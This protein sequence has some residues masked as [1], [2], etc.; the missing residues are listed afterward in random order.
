MAAMTKL[1][2]RPRSFFMRFSFLFVE[3]TPLSGQ[4]WL[5]GQQNFQDLAPRFAIQ[6]GKRG[7]LIT[8]GQNFEQPVIHILFGLRG[9]GIERLVV[10]K[11]AARIFEDPCAQIEVAQ[12][13][14]GGIARPARG[15]FFG[16]A[17]S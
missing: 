4:A 17:G 8:T 10:N 15:E 7:T 13:T 1:A 11:V 3:S 5:R 14:A 12:G 6:S 2:A 9:Q 16:K